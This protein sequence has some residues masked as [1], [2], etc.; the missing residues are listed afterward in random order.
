MAGMLS[1]GRK[2]QRPQAYK[3]GMLTLKE[4]YERL[5]LQY[6][7][8]WWDMKGDRHI[9]RTT[10][11]LVEM[12]LDMALAFR[13]TSLSVVHKVHFVYVCIDSR[14]KASL[15]QQLNRIHSALNI[16]EARIEHI[17]FVPYG[18]QKHAFNSRHY[19]WGVFC[20]HAVKDIE[21][22]GQLL[23]PYDLIRKLVVL[24]HPDEYEAF[25]RDSNP[26][27]TLTKE[28]ADDVIAKTSCPI[29]LQPKPTVPPTT[30]SAWSM[31]SLPIRMKNAFEVE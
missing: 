15:E 16:P 22:I 23:F 14:Q 19:S 24:N 17:R 29:V 31:P 25:D 11:A 3:V 7:T 4:A 1:I 27:C 10:H 6:P 5:G 2:P 18:A 26:I 20:D 28:G 13:I 12:Y 30:F 9:G 21:G 8:K